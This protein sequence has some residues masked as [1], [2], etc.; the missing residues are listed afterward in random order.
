MAQTFVA[1]DPG[2]TADWKARWQTEILSEAKARYCDTQ[3]GEEIGWLMAPIMN[4]F[5]YGYLLTN[6]SRWIDRLID[7]S[8]SWIKRGVMEPDGFIGWP[9]V[10][11]AGTDVDNL[12]DFDADSLLGEAMAFRPIVLMSAVIHH[13]PWLNAQYGGKADEYIKLAKSVFE[14]WDRRGAWRPATNGMITV[15]L[16][17]GIDRKTGAWTTGY[18]DRNGPGQGFSHPDNKAN[19]VA[20]WLLAMY[21]ATGDKIYRDRA[22]GWFSVMKSRLRAGPSGTYLIWNYWEPAGAWDYR[23]NGAPKHWIGVHPKAGYYAIDTEAIVDAYQHNLVFD[24]EDIRRLIATATATS[25]LWPSLAPYDRSIQQR[26][27]EALKPGAWSGL[28]LVPWVLIA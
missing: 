6:D 14:K 10:G 26:T 21:D 9:K 19:M 23:A 2:R 11:A 28:T 12:D 17:F 1:P 24:A 8:D 13:N 16:P 7:W 3:M 25:H 4:G 18:T 5:Y 27:E 22:S 15:V 20:S